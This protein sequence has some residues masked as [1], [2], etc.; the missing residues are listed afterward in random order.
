MAGKS[1]IIE[2]LGDNIDGLTRK[3]AAE[4]FDALFDFIGGRLEDG[5]RVL[6]PGFGSFSISERSARTG[7]N[8]A[9]GEVIAIP[10]SRVVRFKAGKDLKDRVNR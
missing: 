5:D 8:P 4:A 1:E 6:V 3:Q 10:A 2:F 9:T 7:R